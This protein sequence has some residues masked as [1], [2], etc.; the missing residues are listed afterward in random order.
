MFSTYRRSALLTAAAFTVSTLMAA[1]AVAS[2]SLA[3]EPIKD[4]DPSP[5]AQ[6]VAKGTGGAVSSVDVNASKVGLEVLRKGGNATD[7]AVAMASRK[8]VV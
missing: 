1:T 7:A 3:A 5:P 2:P 6:A 4:H 8:S